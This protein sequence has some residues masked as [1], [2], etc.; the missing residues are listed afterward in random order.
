[1]VNAGSFLASP[2]APGEII[3]IFG[4]FLGPQDEEL[5]HLTAANI[6]DTT[7]AGTRVL[8]NGKAT[9]ILFSQSNQVNTIV[10]Y[11]A[12]GKPTASVQLEYQ[13]VRTT[14]LSISVADAAP[15][16]FT[17]DGTGRGPAAMLNEDTSI[18][19]D[20]NPA[21]R[22]SIAVL[23]AT[24]AGLM[25]P[26]SEDGAITGPNLAHP[27]QTVAVLVDG[28]DAKVTYAGSAPGLV[29]G[30]LQVNFRVPA[31][32]KTGSNVGVLLKVGRFTSQSGITF[33]VR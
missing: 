21:D 9:P 27:L 11:S 22:G 2:I 4:S 12:A 30:V 19:F 33:S 3:S 25:S 15:A 1:L 28:V 5:L 23:Y 10:P 18:N 16:I 17:L 7:L 32:A 8:I 6:V 20:L 26:A 29:S 13:G 24:G 14:A 31:Q